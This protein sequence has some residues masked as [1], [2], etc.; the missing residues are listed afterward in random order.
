M[1]FDVQGME[2]HALDAHMD[3]MD[4]HVRLVHMGLHSQAASDKV[5]ALFESHGWHRRYLYV[6][7]TGTTNP[8]GWSS[9]WFGHAHAQDG[10][11]SW[12]N[13][14]F[15]EQYPCAEEIDHQAAPTT[16]VGKLP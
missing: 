3:A 11:G 13:P 2:E 9:S 6:G 1:H 7:T 15:L 5:D 12:L 14:R 4:R 10:C 16:R 8:N